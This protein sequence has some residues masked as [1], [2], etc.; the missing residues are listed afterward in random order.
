MTRDEFVKATAALLAQLQVAG[1]LRL[2]L[3]GALED[4]GALH[5]GLHGPGY[6][7]ETQYEE[8]IRQLLGEAGCPVPGR[9]CRD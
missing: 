7:E 8:E 4:W 2:P 1:S 3:G 9:Y 6:A 5:A